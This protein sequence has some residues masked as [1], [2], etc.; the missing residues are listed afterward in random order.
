[1]GCSGAHSGAALGHLIPSRGLVFVAAEELSVPSYLGWFHISQRAN[2][3][4]DAFG[5][6]TNLLLVDNKGR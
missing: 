5:D 1:V 4:L 3:V 2:A 6:L